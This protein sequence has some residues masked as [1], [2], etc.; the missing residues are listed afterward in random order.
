MTDLRKPHRNFKKACSKYKS[1]CRVNLCVNLPHTEKD[2]IC[3]KN[4]S[5][6][7]S[8]EFSNSP[9]NRLLSEGTRGTVNM[10]L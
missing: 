6:R 8:P 1:L 4:K 10:G 2:E 3:R 5:L 7:I 9:G